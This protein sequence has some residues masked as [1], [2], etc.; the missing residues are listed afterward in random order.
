MPCCVA[1][2]LFRFKTD[3]QV[4]N[5]EALER[6][7]AAILRGISWFQFFRPNKIVHLVLDEA[8]FLVPT[9]NDTVDDRASKLGCFQRLMTLA[10]MLG[11]D[12]RSCQSVLS[13][14][15]PEIC[16]MP[17]GAVFARHV[18]DSSMIP[19]IREPM[20]SFV[21]CILCHRPHSPIFS[22]DWNKIRVCTV[23]PMSHADN[24]TALTRKFQRIRRLP[25]FISVWPFLP[26]LD[27][28]F[29]LMDSWQPLSACGIRL[30]FPSWFRICV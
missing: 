1:D 11:H 8:T 17:V 3:V 25:L 28:C 10:I 7:R 9:P 14:S 26:Q 15:T 29:L 4:K 27:P 5:S 20:L 21:S 16:D 12:L 2:R 24:I 23:L 13:S 30:F 19:E 22:S 18:V 6:L